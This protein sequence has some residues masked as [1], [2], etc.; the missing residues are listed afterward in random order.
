MTP[1][2][3]YGR[4]AS[5]IAMAPRNLAG[6]VNDRSDGVVMARSVWV[7]EVAKRA[8]DC[9]FGRGTVECP[10]AAELRSWWLGVFGSPPF[11]S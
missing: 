9:I 8:A 3:E 6:C 10:R 1:T 2:A 4:V 5:A 7:A 11:Q